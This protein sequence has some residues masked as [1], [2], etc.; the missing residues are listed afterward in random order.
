[1][2]QPF[3]YNPQ[4]YYQQPQEMNHPFN[5]PQQW[6]T[7]PMQQNMMQNPFQMPN[8]YFP[9]QQMNQPMFYPPNRQLAQQLGGMG[10]GPA[11]PYPN[12]KQGQG[13]GQGQGQVKKTTAQSPNVLAQFKSTDGNYDINKM[14]N[15]AGIMVNTINQITGMVKQ[16]GGFFVK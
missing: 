11:F 15:T 1:M 6:P 3:Q 8:S 12:Q 4:M 9:S 16:V 2:N 7:M 5:Y 13:Q 10:P 14:I